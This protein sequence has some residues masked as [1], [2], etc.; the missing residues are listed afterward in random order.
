M[1]RALSGGIGQDSN[2][3]RQAKAFEST[4]DTT[5]SPRIDDSAESL[6]SVGAC[7]VFP[8]PFQ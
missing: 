1:V 3:Q 2:S 6:K 5:D 8:L 7:H 4:R